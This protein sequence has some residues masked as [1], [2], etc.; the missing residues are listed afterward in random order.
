MSD[1]GRADHGW[2]APDGDGIRSLRLSDPKRSSLKGKRLRRASPTPGGLGLDAW[3]ADERQLLAEWVR[4]AGDTPIRHSTL[5]AGAGAA[6]TMLADRLLQRL[7]QGGAVEIEESHERGHWW[8]RQIRFLVP[9]ALRAGLGLAEPDAARRAYL[10]A[11]GRPLGHPTLARAADAL[12]AQPS[13]PSP[14]PAACPG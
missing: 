8:P 9:S 11:R 10:E 2:S 7:L 14:R 5:M 4:R 12:D 13:T 3:P 6:R 1:E